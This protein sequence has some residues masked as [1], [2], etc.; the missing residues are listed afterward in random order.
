MRL[1]RIMVIPAILLLLLLGA[2][3][4]V[5]FSDFEASREPVVA[6]MG[7]RRYVVTHGLGRPLAELGPEAIP[8]LVKG[9]DE[10]DSR[11]HTLKVHVWKLLP[12]KLQSKW[13][14]HAP[15]DSIRL[16]SSCVRALEM[17]GPEAVSA[18]PKLI[19]LAKS[20]PV[21]SGVA[22]SA[23]AHMA[24][25]SPQAAGFLVT[26]LRDGDG[27]LKMKV[28]NAFASA[29]FTPPDAVPL[30]VAR[31]ENY[32]PVDRRS[33]LPLNEMS[34]LS[35]CGSEAAPAALQLAKYIDQ[36]GTD[37]AIRA[38]RATGPAAIVALPR[39]L[40]ILRDRGEWSIQL[41]PGIFAILA[42]LGTNGA[43]ALPA[44]T[45]GLSDANP[46][47]RALAAVGIARIAGPLEFAVPRLIEELENRGPSGESLTIQASE[48]LIGLHHRQL[49]ALLLG[50]L[51]EKATNA[52]PNL[53]KAVNGSERWL[54]PYAADAIWKI[55]NDATAVLPA[56]IAE[57]PNPISGAPKSGE[58]HQMLVLNVL[59]QMGPAAEPA[60]PAIRA[61]MKS[62]LGVRRH[63]YTALQ[64]INT[65]KK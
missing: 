14:N 1:R 31:L 32:V 17:F 27:M 28:V 6:G 57:L 49:S 37:K 48:H 53:K 61:T 3:V 38:L 46:G 25:D 58:I 7:V 9:L 34:A 29:G 47:V 26:S 59:A 30:L 10:K 51:G 36:G 39:L 33:P 43:A 62:N 44:L 35:V 11:L 19:E 4:F 2:I 63:G 12:R 50:E 55:S 23:L 45:N 40:A 56:L 65:A 60:V 8:W 5:A 13:R 15:I 16:R 24:P 41:R 42:G 64:K 18:V 22:C 54:H 52:L 21:L 20:D